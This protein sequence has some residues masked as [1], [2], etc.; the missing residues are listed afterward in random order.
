LGEGGLGIGDQGALARHVRFEL[1]QP[2]VELGQA[3]AG[4]S[5]LGI[6]RVAGDQQAL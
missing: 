4:A 6:E 3:L 1:R 2:A 5:F